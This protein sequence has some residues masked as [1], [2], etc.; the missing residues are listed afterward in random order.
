M[1]PKKLTPTKWAGLVGVGT[2]GLS[3]V[4]AGGLHGQPARL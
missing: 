3:V 1:G 4:V 2:W